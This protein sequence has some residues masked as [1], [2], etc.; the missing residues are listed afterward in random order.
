MKV[1]IIG[2]KNDQ[3]D[4]CCFCLDLGNIR[5]GHVTRAPSSA[6][7]P[8]QRKSVKH[9]ARVRRNPAATKVNRITSTSASMS[10]CVVFG[11]V[12][13]FRPFKTNAPCL[14]RMLSAPLDRGQ[15]LQGG[16]WKG[17]QDSARVLPPP[18]C[19]GAFRPDGEG[20]GTQGCVASCHH[21]RSLP[22][23]RWRRATMLTSL[24]RRPMGLL[25]P[26]Y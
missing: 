20:R 15:A 22:V 18:K 13:A 25:S 2:G 17:R 12:G 11:T 26:V 6:G 14:I 16:C 7:R 4:R 1:H 9:T 23:G 24:R 5:A 19:E 21:N 8:D 3:I 10:S